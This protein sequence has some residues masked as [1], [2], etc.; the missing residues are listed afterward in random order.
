MRKGSTTHQLAPT[1][2]GALL[3]RG[4]VL[5]LQP[6]DAVADDQPLA[7]QRAPGRRNS[8]EV[9]PR[10]RIV[11]ELA[12]FDEGAERRDDGCREGEVTDATVLGAPREL[13]IGE[14]DVGVAIVRTLE[15]VGEGAKEGRTLEG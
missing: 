13:L 12:D 14:G 2:E 3:R 1:A 15:E 9:F 6:G 11:L 5:P 4:T 8:V 7:L 10:R